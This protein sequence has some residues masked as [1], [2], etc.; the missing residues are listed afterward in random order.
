MCGAN[1]AVAQRAAA[2]ALGWLADLA[3]PALLFGAALAFAFGLDHGG[4]EEGRGARGRPGGLF[5]F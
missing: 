5:F 3:V 2:A 1:A 4:G